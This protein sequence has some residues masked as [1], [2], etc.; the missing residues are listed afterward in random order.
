LCFLNEEL[1]MQSSEA[2]VKRRDRSSGATNE[3]ITQGWTIKKRDG[4]VEDFNPDKITQVVIKCFHDGLKRPLAAASRIADRVSFRVINL[5]AAQKLTHPHIEDVQRAVIQQL[6]SDGFYDAAEHY[7][8]YREER[9]KAREE[10]KVSPELAEII[11]RDIKRYFKTPLQAYQF[12][13]KFARWREQ[14]KRRETWSECNERTFKWFATLPQYH[15]LS[16]SEVAWL[17]QHMLS[18]SASPALRVVQMAGPALERDHIGAYNCTAAPIIDLFSFA[19]ALYILMQGCGFGFSV[20]SQ[21]ISHLPVVKKQV[22]L[23]Q[24]PVF[25]IKDTTEGWCD[26]LYEG[27]VT[28]FDGRDIEFDTSY[29]RPA[30]AK[31]KTKG[32]RASGPGPLIDLLNFVRKTV[33]NAQG[34]RLLDIEVHDICCMIGKIV[35]VGGVR[36]AS[37]ISLSD[38][39]SQTM[40][41]AKHGAW[42]EKNG[43]R[44]MANN[45][46]VYDEKPTIEMF[47][48][49]WLSLVKSQSGER[50]I[51]NRQGVTK[52]KPARRSE[53]TFITNPCAEIILRRWQMC[54]L[55]IAVVRGHETEDELVDKVQAAAYFGVIQSCATNFNYV[56]K[57]W[58]ENCEDERL[59]GVDIMGHLDHPLLRPGSSGREG[60]VTRMREAVM[61]VAVNLSS[62]FKINL[63]AANTCLKPGGDSSVL[64]DTTSLAPYWAEHQIRRTRESVHSPVCKMLKDQGVP[65]EPA[66]ED[67]K[68]LVAF[69]WPKKNKDNCVKREDMTALEQLD[70]WLFWKRTWCEHSASVTIYVKPDEWLEVGAWVWKHFDD[71]TGIS[72]LPWDNGSYRT[73]PNETLTKSQYEDMLSTFPDID[74]AQLVRYEEDDETVSSRTY[75]CAGGL[76]EL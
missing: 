11:N 7:T 58:R 34:R 31:L 3:E 51:F 36:R 50:G 53:Q 2:A 64:F 70:N 39:N 29:V 68:G 19:E 33:L 6:W 14:D 25:T 22:A 44:S 62:R 54:N 60:L 18:L 38:L 10:K 42:Y 15:L 63:S 52:N 40:R 74:W 16:D 66:A 8:I 35:Q 56:R 24:T 57:E 71:I 67:E 13:S 46:A 32:G 61:A 9:R 28:W 26:A 20:E 75:A 72:F 49:E 59:L 1:S 69:A 27:M 21:F 73:V 45:S 37:C 47:M 12:Y 23:K 48:D 43:Q 76:C 41:L 5:L 17:K 65:W 30:G 55:S 4:R